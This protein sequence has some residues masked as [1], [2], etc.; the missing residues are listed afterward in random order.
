M[1]HVVADDGALKGLV[2]ALVLELGRMDADDNEG[3]P[4]TLFKGPELFK[5]V[6]A[7]D[8][9]ERPEVEED[10]LAPQGSEREI[11]P[12]VDPTAPPD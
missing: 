11:L 10:Y 7:V 3:V 8:A 2:V 5:D 12:G 4:K 1:A 9:A 6:E